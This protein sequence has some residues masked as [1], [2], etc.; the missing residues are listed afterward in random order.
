[1]ATMI[2]IDDFLPKVLIHAPNTSDLIAFEYIIEAAREL[3]ERV[4]VWRE[5][6]TL[7]AFGP[8]DILTTLQDADIQ[9]IDAAR[10]NGYDLQPK[11]T[12]WLDEEKPGWDLDDEIKGNASYVTQV[13]RNSIRVVPATN[14]KLTARFIL[15]PAYGAVSMPDVL[16]SEYGQEV[17]RGAAAKI[18]ARPSEDA[19]PQLA[20]YHGEWFMARLNKLHLDAVRGQQGA[21]LRTTG[22]YF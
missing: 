5:R 4:D 2:D 8:E 9:R 12:A 1:M 3:C 20:L 13:A 11:T 7:E 6:E 22:S 14:G 15:K 10:L 17:G 21:R 18:L 19:N 16:L